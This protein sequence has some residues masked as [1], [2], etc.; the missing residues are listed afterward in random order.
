MEEVWK[1]LKELPIYQISNLGKIRSV[2]TY[3]NHS[4][5]Y[6][7]CGTRFVKGKILKTQISNSGYEFI[8]LRL[9]NKK[10]NY[11][12]HRLVASYFLKNPNNYKYVNHI[13]GN[14]LNNNAENLEWCTQSHNVK[15]SYRLGL[16]KPYT[17][18]MMFNYVPW[19]KGKKLK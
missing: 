13:D 8:V 3:K 5:Q 14:K 4:N 6:G 16:Q 15:E 2:D 18:P 17:P 12:I 1:T 11:S 7:K 19:N 10:K 9:N